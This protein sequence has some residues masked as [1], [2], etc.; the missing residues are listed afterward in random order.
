MME[1]ALES[2]PNKTARIAGMWYLLLTVFS[3]VGIVFADS[4]F[5]VSGDAAATMARI[6]AD[7]GLF[8]LTIAC[9]LAGQV[10]QIF[11][12]LTLYRLFKPVD[13]NQA[14]T[15]L[16]L[17]VAMVP[18]AFLNM[19]AKFAP[20]ILGDSSF[21]KAFDSVQLHSLAMLFL[22]LQQTGIILASV[23]WGLWLFPL[24]ILVL[25]SGYFPKV[26]GVLLFVGGASYLVDSGLAIVFPKV[27]TLL[28]PFTSTLSGVGELPFVLW[29][30][31][32]GVRANKQ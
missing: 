8:R 1:Q 28:A 30:V 31:I 16:A 32:V 5:Y 15:L 3:I 27:R 21:A 12:G 6:S 19:L 17:V 29:I 18:I 22:E 7:E 24:G 11:V 4:R 2:P 14:R 13:Q 20:L 10:C 26:L 23:F 9:N 25:K